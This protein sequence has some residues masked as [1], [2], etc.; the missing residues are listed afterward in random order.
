MTLRMCADGGLAGMQMMA[1]F[2]Q[3]TAGELYGMPWTFQQSRSPIIT[4]SVYNFLSIVMYRSTST[5]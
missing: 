4:L 1:D 3:E 2:F 5:A